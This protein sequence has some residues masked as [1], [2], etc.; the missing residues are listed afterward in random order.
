MTLPRTY[1][2]QTSP[3][4]ISNQLFFFL[5][6]SSAPFPLLLLPTHHSSNST[7]PPPPNLLTDPPPPPTL[8][9]AR[10]SSKD[11]HGA[12][13]H[14]H[15]PRIE[16]RRRKNRHRPESGHDGQTDTFGGINPSCT[17][18]RQAGAR[19]TTA[20]QIWCTMILGCQCGRRGWVRLCSG[21]FGGGRHGSE[22]G[23]VWVLERKPGSC[24]L[25][26]FFLDCSMSSWGID[27]AD[28]RSGCRFCGFCCH[29]QGIRRW[30]RGRCKESMSQKALS[31]YMKRIK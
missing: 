15:Q 5:E 6:P 12:R 13:R 23:F 11:P 28:I 1:S 17:R 19:T 31:V 25:L 30:R 2:A 10:H 27:R 24:R 14:L 3:K 16:R 4:S 22:G 20:D 18:I 21:A 29:M 7:H 26:G 8:L 9:A